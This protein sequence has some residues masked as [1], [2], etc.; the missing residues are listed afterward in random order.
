MPELENGQFG[1]G[2]KSGTKAMTGDEALRW[3]IGSQNYS[4]DRGS[5]EKT[6]DSLI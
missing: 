2:R 5:I 3:I 4:E 1:T 6:M